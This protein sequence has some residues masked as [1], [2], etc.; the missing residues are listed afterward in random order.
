MKMFLA[1]LLCFYTMNGYAAEIKED[2]VYNQ[3]KYAKDG[4][5][6]AKLFMAE[7]LQLDKPKYQ[8]VYNNYKRELEILPFSGK[9]SSNP[10]LEADLNQMNSDDQY[11]YKRT[12]RRGGN[13]YKRY[14]YRH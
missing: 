10:E 4:K 13:L 1:L 12:K 8:R 7:Y 2:K 11:I 9:L 3:E 6:A 14:K 5:A